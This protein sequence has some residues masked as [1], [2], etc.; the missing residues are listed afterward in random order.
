MLLRETNGDKMNCDGGD[1]VRR[2]LHDRRCGVE[3][4]RDAG[5]GLDVGRLDVWWG[6]EEPALAT[7]PRLHADATASLHSPVCCFDPCDDSF[8]RYTHTGR[9]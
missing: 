6:E 2:R 3:V 4:E 5:L 1:W 9:Y 8:R 7:S